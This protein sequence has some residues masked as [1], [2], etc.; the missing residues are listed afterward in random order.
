M[1]LSFGI[2]PYYTEKPMSRDEFMNDLPEMLMKNGI[3]ADDY[4]V[5]VGGSFGHRTSSF[6]GAGGAAGASSFLVL[7]LFINLMAIKMEKAI[8]K[9]SIVVCKKF[10]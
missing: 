3:K 4:V 8:I 2:Y 9:K 6:E 5:V 10:P 1:A 7:S